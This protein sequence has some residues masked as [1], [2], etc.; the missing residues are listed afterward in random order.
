MAEDKSEEAMSGEKMK[1]M[2]DAIGLEYARGSRDISDGL[3]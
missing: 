1:G 2:I 3:A